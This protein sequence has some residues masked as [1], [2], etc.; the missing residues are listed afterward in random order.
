MAETTGRAA[1]RVEWRLTKGKEKNVF[2][3]ATSA[4]G[5]EEHLALLVG[6]AYAA[7]V[8]ATDV[9]REAENKEG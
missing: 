8:E 5:M 9:I 3:V 2:V 1:I 6:G 7:F 4:K